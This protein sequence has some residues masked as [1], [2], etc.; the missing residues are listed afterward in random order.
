MLKPLGEL[1]AKAIGMYGSGMAKSI[2]V[3]AN[4]YEPLLGS[5]AGSMDAARA[6]L[7]VVNDVAALAAMPDDSPTLLKGKPAGRKVVAWSEPCRLPRS[8]RSARP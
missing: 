7:K 3:L 2:D 5:L 8:M 4:P 1:T 6:G